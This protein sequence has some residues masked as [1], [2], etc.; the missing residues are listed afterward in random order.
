MLSPES[1]NYI[2]YLQPIILGNY[3]HFCY[4]FSLSASFHLIASII[5]RL[6]NK[7][8]TSFSCFLA[9]QQGAQQLAG[10]LINVWWP[11]VRALSF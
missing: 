8:P 3:S 5:L 7:T 9:D 10:P 6:R 11:S 4:L 2:G 1:V